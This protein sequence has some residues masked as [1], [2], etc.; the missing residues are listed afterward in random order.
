MFGRKG[1]EIC[2]FAERA[3]IYVALFRI[4]PARWFQPAV[5]WPRFR[6]DTY[7]VMTHALQLLRDYAGRYHGVGH[8]EDG[9]ELAAELAVCQDG[10]RIVLEL[11]VFD[12]NGNHA[13]ADRLCIEADQAATVL[14]ASGGGRQ[15]ARRCRLA[16]TRFGAQ[17][18]TLLFRAGEPADR[19]CYREEITLVLHRDGGLE[20]HAALGAPGEDLASRLTIRLSSS[21][22][23]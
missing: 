8:D 6:R 9:D 3:A 14:V 23:N 5:A 4:R 12:D 10:D 19:A 11:V 18:T 1:R 17:S 20:F 7:A 13:H 15:A 2:C 16:A 22:G 21:S